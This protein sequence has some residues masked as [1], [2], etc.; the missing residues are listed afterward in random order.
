MPCFKIFFFYSLFFVSMYYVDNLK[1]LMFA[2]NDVFI[3]KF[4][5]FL[6]IN[7]CIMA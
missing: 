5:N 7:L 3:F 1:K 6:K 4:K 2:K